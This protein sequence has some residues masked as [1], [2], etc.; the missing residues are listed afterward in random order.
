MHS[1]LMR[2][3]SF[4]KVLAEIDPQA[5]TQS[6]DGFSEANP[7]MA[8]LASNVRQTSDDHF[9]DTRLVEFDVS[10]SG[11]GLDYDPGD[12]CMVMPRNSK[13]NVE[14]FFQL[15]SSL[16]REDR[17][18]LEKADSFELPHQWQLPQV[19]LIEIDLLPCSNEISYAQG[20]TIEYCVEHYWDIQSIPRR[21]FFEMLSHF[22]QDILEKEKLI[23]FNTAEGQ[24]GTSRHEKRHC[25]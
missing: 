13:E 12:V 1:T 17:I 8:R 6:V 21:Y 23:E 9:Q 10:T 15:F 4:A 25:E 5:K 18:W 20:S 2:Q 16:K 11:G 19:Q 3:F 24:Q 14:A 22:S 7:F